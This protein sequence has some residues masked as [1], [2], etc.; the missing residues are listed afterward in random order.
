MQAADIN[1]VKS[2][3]VNSIGLFAYVE[4]AF[5]TILLYQPQGSDHLHTVYVILVLISLRPFC[6]PLQMRHTTSLP[7]PYLRQH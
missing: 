5:Y 1:A 7:D 6:N 3:I 2:E 4:E